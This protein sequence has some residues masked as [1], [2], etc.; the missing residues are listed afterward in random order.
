MTDV[1][2]CMQKVNKSSLSPSPILLQ[3]IVDSI[4]DIIVQVDENKVYTWSNQRG[5]DFFG[6]DL[7]G[8]EAKHY[9]EG[10]QDVYKKVAPI[11]NGNNETIY[12]ESW[13]RRKDGQKRLLAWWC[14]SMK[15]ENGKVLGAISTA[16]DITDKAKL[17]ETLEKS[18]LV[19]RNIVDLLP[20]RIFW[21]DVNLTYLGC[22]SI[23][24]KDAG[25]NKPEDLIGKDDFQ[26]G[27]KEQANFYREDD[28]KVLKSGVAKLNYEE[29][30]TTPSGETIW[31]NT[32]KIPLVDDSGITVGVVGTYM[33]I[34]E[35]KKSE[36]LLKESE[37]RSNKAQS[38]SHV[39]IWELDLKTNLV[40][41]S[42]EAFRIYGL[43]INNTQQ[44]PL[45][46]VQ[47]SVE[48]EYRTELD[49]ALNLLVTQEKPYNVE[50]KIKRGT[51][52]GIR[53]I[54]S[55]AELIK[56]ISGAPTKVLGTIQDITEFKTVE[57][58]L[59]NK[60]EDLEKMNK[61]M[62][63]REL[64]MIEL[65]EKIKELESKLQNK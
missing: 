18:Q 6:E 2:E 14:C 50:F 34:T 31:L 13:Q 47:K 59:R 42:H 43:E 15:D 45:E 58:Q 57:N 4:Q 8:H 24:A 39:G 20:V 19:L 27:W 22:N 36:I 37:E 1:N 9:F 56:N 3:M 40:W 65:K 11:F 5:Y 60:N 49:T 17:E 55:K 54:V 53:D 41:G 28:M 12:L 62:V 35:R 33:D 10:E 46:T 25:M 23:F 63:D 21:K 48:L 61:A 26:M 32:N 64:R 52:S 16:R 7:L 44:F 29:P 38:V 30:Q 51:D